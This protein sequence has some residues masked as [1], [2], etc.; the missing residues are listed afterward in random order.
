[1]YYIYIVIY[2]PERGIIL[3]TSFNI[4]SVLW[5]VILLSFLWG[6][7]FIGTLMYIYIY[8]NIRRRLFLSVILF[9][10]LGLT[11]A[12]SEIL[13]I[14]LGSSGSVSTGMEFHRIEALSVL[15]FI[16][17]CPFFLNEILDLGKN[18]RKLNTWFIR[19]GIIISIL[20][21]ITAYIRPELF[22]GFNRHP[23]F[24]ITP[25]NASRGVPGPLYDIRGL[26]VMFIGIYTIGSIITDIIYHHRF[27]YL[28]LI[29]AG[30]IIAII[31]GL[32]DIIL[33]SFEQEHG[34]FS[35]RVF[36]YFCLGL[37]L[38]I[39]LSMISVM[40]LFIDQ[41][42]QIENARKIDSLGVFAGGLAHDFNN[43]LSGIVGNVSLL[44]ESSS[45][46]DARLEIL[47]GIEY[48]AYRAKALTL[49]LLTF[50]KGGAP[51][52]ETASIRE[53]VEE[54]VNFVLSGSSIRPRFTI[55]E[56]LKNVRADAGQISQVI[57]NLVINALDATRGKEGFIDIRIENSIHRF[58]G[59]PGTGTGECIK[60][61]VR[62]YGRGISSRELPYIFDPYYTTKEKGS[63][64]GLAICYSIIKK[65]EGDIAVHSRP[66]EGTTMTIYIPA[67]N[68]RVFNAGPAIPVKSKFSGKILVM[69]DDPILR[70]TLERMLV[71]LGFSV[72]TVPDGEKAIEAVKKSSDSGR[73][74]AAVIMDLTVS[75]GMGGQKAAGIIT[76]VSPGL[77]L[78]V[79]SGYS[80][81][82]VMA[83]YRDYGFSAR[84]VKPV[85]LDDLR[86]VM[87]EVLSDTNLSHN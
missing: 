79:A 41:D 50:A 19:A 3:N 72:K 40:R 36:S 85:S 31:F 9:G 29:L 12:G 37:T 32:T 39:I 22:I 63:G 34:L 47:T 64:L 42:K 33:G 27:R 1:M 83:H 11:Y 15:F 78:I 86:L 21:I 54:T 49:Q 61:E 77:P 2:Q 8:I 71:H 10:I 43:I 6:I 18:Y 65:H 4:G 28:G 17:M 46:D 51:I 13:V 23:G 52:K 53:I 60:I 56:N 81:D 68:D 7:I 55:Q 25:W 73:E 16:P 84:L 74:L 26:I 24:I 48:A 20:V 58:P 30:I 80:D 69:D 82:P 38:F 75:G 45:R 76:S 57:Q 35:K 67:V 70:T 59:V 66:G 5:P 14:A 62:D 44:L 87:L